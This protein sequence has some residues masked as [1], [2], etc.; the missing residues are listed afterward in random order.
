M[1]SDFLQGFLASADMNCQLAWCLAKLGRTDTA[2][3]LFAIVSEE[4]FLPWLTVHHT[5]THTHTHTHE[6]KH[7]FT[8]VTLLQLG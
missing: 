1:L 5:H 6:V 4:Y 7:V 8:V 2:K 3:D